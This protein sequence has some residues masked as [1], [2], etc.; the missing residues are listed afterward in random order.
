[1]SIRRDETVPM[2]ID[3]DK[4]VTFP[5]L[6]ERRPRRLVR[7]SAK[8]LHPQNALTDS[9][10][11]VLYRPTMLGEV[12]RRRTQKDRHVSLTP[13]RCRV[14]RTSMD[15]HKHALRHL[16]IAPAGPQKLKARGLR[17]PPVADY[18]QVMNVN[19][20]GY[21]LYA[22]QAYP[23]LARRRG[24]MIHIASDAGIWGEQATGLYSVT[25]AAVVML[26]KMLALDGGRDGVRSNVLCPGDIWPGMRHMAPPGE[27]D[28]AESGSEWPVP[29]IG[30]VGQASDVATAAVFYASDQA[31]FITGTTLLVDGGMT[32]GYLQRERDAP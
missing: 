14:R 18:D 23:H 4:K 5:Y 28:R 11:P 2:S 20:R 24:C 15:I 26:G 19:V 10:Q 21:L 16:S 32:A 9:I 8:G 30:R 22:Q 7:T 29:P 31:G 3:A 27:Q 6:A 12:N 25:K 1:M 13:L 17:P